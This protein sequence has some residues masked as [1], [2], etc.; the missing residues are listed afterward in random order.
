[1][2]SCSRLLTCLVCVVPFL[3]GCL[4]RAGVAV[5]HQNGKSKLGFDGRMGIHPL[6]LVHPVARYADAGLGVAARSSG[7]VGFYVE[8]AVVTNKTPLVASSRVLDVFE[9]RQLVAVDATLGV[10]SET[11]PLRPGID[12]LL[13]TEGA[14]FMHEKSNKSFSWGEIGVGVYLSGRFDRKSWAASLGVQGRGCACLAT[15]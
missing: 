13:I 4:F 10:A 14:G 7:H 2:R 15:D 8:G 3:G 12:V 6:Q 1:M 9:L 5:E 11:G